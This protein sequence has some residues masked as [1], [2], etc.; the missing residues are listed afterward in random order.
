MRA[1]SFIHASDTHLDE[2]SV[3]RFWRLREITEE[4]GVDF[5]LMTGDL[6]R[7]ALRGSEETARERFELFRPSGSVD[8]PR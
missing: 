5:V 3:P 8:S 4:R 6:I 2:E 7:D 1:F